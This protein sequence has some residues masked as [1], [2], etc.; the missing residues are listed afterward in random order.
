M[1]HIR[2]YSYKNEGEPYRFYSR[3]HSIVF[4]LDAGAVVTT[5]RMKNRVLHENELLLVESLCNFHVQMMAGCRMFILSF[6]ALPDFMESAIMK[7]LTPGVVQ[8]SDMEGSPILKSNVYLSNY[9]RSLRVFESSR[10]GKE[11]VDL[12][13]KEFFFL[14]KDFYDIADVELFLRPVRSK[15]EWVDFKVDAMRAYTPFMSVK[16]LSVKLDKSPT[17]L[18]RLFDKH[19]KNTP[20]GWIRENNKR[21]LLD[22][23][24]DS[25]RSL[26]DI[27]MELNVSSVQQLSRYCRINF[28]FTPRQ[29]R[30]QAERFHVMR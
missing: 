5:P 26:A 21:L 17:T 29:L 18:V 10:C 15:L 8:A 16:Q 28:G 12:K 24:S 30:M 4:F 11:L 19:F 3:T 1:M 2:Y 6:D 13:S 9:A 25:S 27:A 14:L 7:C 22:M 20:A 23:L